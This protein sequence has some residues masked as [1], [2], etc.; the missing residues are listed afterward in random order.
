MH[1]SD[2]LKFKLLDLSLLQMFA[3]P[4]FPS[5]LKPYNIAFFGLVILFINRKN[6][7]TFDFKSFFINSSIYLLMILSLLYS[8]N[9]HYAFK[10][11]ETMA[12]LIIFPMIFSLYPQTMI[13]KLQHNRN[14]YMIVFFGS[15]LLFNAICQDVDIFICLHLFNCLIV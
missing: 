5:N 1:I 7:F 3:L 13:K 14:R 12:S 4:L 15:V 11:L 10:K 9:L 8:E 6:D 2:K